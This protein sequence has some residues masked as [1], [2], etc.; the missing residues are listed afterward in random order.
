MATESFLSEFPP[1]TTE[2]WEHIIREKITGAE[3]ASKLIWHPEEGFAVKPYYRAD[4][5][6][7][8]QFLDAAPGTFPFVRGTRSDGDW[9]IRE[10]IDLVDAANANSAACAAVVGGAEEIAFRRPKLG[11]TA[12]LAT[13]LGN[14]HEIPIV[15]AGS[16]P[17]LVR[18]VM[19]RI[20]LHPHG[21]SIS[22]EL[23]PLVDLELSAELIRNGPQGFRPFVIDAEQFQER[24]AS[25]LEEVGFAL[26]AGVD[27]VAEMQARGLSLDRITRCM[28]FSFAMGPE[29]F[30]QIAKLRAFRLVWAK[31]VESFGGAEE[32]AR[33]SI[34]GCTARWNATLYDPQ[35]NILRATT[36]ALSA[37]LGGAD[38]ISISPFD[39]CFRYPDE[40][41][42]R[43]ARNT[44][45]IFKQEAFLS[46]VS[47]PVGGSYLIEA[48]TNSIAAR[49]WKLFQELE[50]AGGYRKAV[51]TGL[52][53]S[54]LEKRLQS[55]DE[56]V[57]FRR[58]ALTGTNR[59]ADASEHATQP[60]DASQS[61]SSARA[62]QYFESLRLRTQHY[63]SKTGRRP[64][65]V[66]AEIG[67]AKMRSARSQFAADFLA[68]AGLTAEK[69][70]FESAERIADFDADVI[71]LCSSDAEYLSIAVELMQILKVR[72]SAAKVIIAG[73]PGNAE[74]LRD[75]GIVEFIHL[76]SNAVVVLGRIQ[77]LIG[78]KD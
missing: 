60:I 34:H 12:D 55:R 20:S 41:S 46:R 47:D 30:I 16:E 40:S 3:Y 33:T 10:E 51:G 26:S 53:A 27:F 29:F 64:R 5:L 62:A 28:S 31:S 11:G 61:A 70:F 71:V 4:D 63:T 13:L 32:T 59:F 48:L 38:S 78:I 42:R 73:N 7:G 8:I 68:C 75:V 36:E 49:A 37:V 67:D 69:S 50:S 24:A 77:Q 22:T 56:A 35:V 65:I 15:F 66:L 39:E 44:Q 74:Q 2:Q 9:R 54:V 52:I 17:G 6:A 14:L 25:S 45:I 19:E 1:I 21:T 58:R 23:D 18:L 76:L 43:L 72:G 57:A